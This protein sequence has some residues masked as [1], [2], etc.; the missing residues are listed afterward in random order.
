M[1]QTS[2]ASNAIQ[3]TTK[4]VYDNLNR[5]VQTQSPNPTT[6]VIGGGPISVNTFDL[7]GRLVSAKDPLNRIT[8]YFYDD[9]DRLKKVVGADPDG[10]VGGNTTD[11]IPSERLSV[12][13]SFVFQRFRNLPEAGYSL[14]LLMNY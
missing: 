12:K 6:G 5:L 1:T 3:K 7:V 9:L 13:V 14:V 4:F 2:T 11:K 10:V 8:S